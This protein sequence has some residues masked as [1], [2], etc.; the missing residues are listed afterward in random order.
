MEDS[1]YR[2]VDDEEEQEVSDEEES[3]IRAQ[4]K[5]L[6]EKLDSIKSN[7]ELQRIADGGIFQE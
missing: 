2:S 7:K 5:S 1:A 6:Q 3:S 4:L